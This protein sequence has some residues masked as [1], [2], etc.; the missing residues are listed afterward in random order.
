[1]TVEPALLQ[2]YVVALRFVTFELEPNP[3]CA[4]DYLKVFCQ[5]GNLSEFVV[6]LQ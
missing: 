1:M 4:Y 3:R 6:Y 2:E 5:E